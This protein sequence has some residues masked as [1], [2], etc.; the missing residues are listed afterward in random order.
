[1][2]NINNEKFENFSGIF[3]APETGQ[4]AAIL[5]NAD[6][7]KCERFSTGQLRKDDND[8]QLDS[9]AKMITIL[10]CD[11]M[12]GIDADELRRIERDDDSI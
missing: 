5:E 6:A 7:S 11:A 2:S 8:S 1:M 3:E 4:V 9:C 12:Q 10:N